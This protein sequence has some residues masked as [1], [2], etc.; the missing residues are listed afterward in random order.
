MPLLASA[1]FQPPEAAH[2]V[3]LVE[4]QL[5]VEASPLATV[6]GTAVKMAVGMVA[7]GAVGGGLIVGWSVLPQA[8]SKSA[9]PADPTKERIRITSFNESYVIRSA[10]AREIV[11]SFVM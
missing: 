8:T 5:S 3:A 11:S 9:A 10:C 6:D 4:L 2:D 1:P 7:T